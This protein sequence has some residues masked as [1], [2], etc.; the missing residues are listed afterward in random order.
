MARTFNVCIWCLILLAVFGATMI[1][2]DDITVPFEGG[3]IVVRP[4][5]IRGNV[6]ELSFRIE[7]HTSHPWWTMVLQFDISGVCNGE[8]KHWLLSAETSLG[9]SE[10]HYVAN[11]YKEIVGSLRD[12]VDGCHTEVIKAS[13][14]RADNADKHFRSENEAKKDAEAAENAKRLEAEW[15]RKEAEANARLAKKRAEEQIRTAEES[16]KLRAGCALSY[17]NTADK[18][19]RDLTVQE[20]Q[21]VRACQALGLYPPQ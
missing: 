21:Q 17:Q 20:E 13:V 3:S 12:K 1:G 16:R 7:N 15:L 10:D 6:P 11:A 18:K 8:P 2:G 14:E 9:W 19:V 5:F 4:Q